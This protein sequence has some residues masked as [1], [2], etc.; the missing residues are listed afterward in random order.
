MMGVHHI[1]RKLR[2]NQASAAS[3]RCLQPTERI[4]H[5]IARRGARSRATDPHCDHATGSR[6]I[7]SWLSQISLFSR[8]LFPV[9]SRKFPAEILGNFLQV[10]GLSR[11]FEPLSLTS[12]VNPAIFPVFLE[13]CLMSAVRSQPSTHA[14]KATR[15]SPSYPESA[16]QRW[17]SLCTKDVDRPARVWLDDWSE[18][19]DLN[20]RPLVSQSRPLRLI[21]RCAAMV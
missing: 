20:L 14:A 11:L 9:R 4:R 7:S 17:R 3:E 10:I 2:V 15:V 13:R 16:S 18:R 8:K 5:L 19:E 1:L 6:S 21:Y 12:G